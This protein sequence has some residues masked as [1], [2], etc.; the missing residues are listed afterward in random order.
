MLGHVGAGPGSNAS[1][2]SISLCLTG[3]HILDVRAASVRRAAVGIEGDRIVAIGPDDQIASRSRQIV[4]VAGQTIV[5][6]YIEPHGH[7]IIANPVEFPCR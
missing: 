7:V 4:D 1:P 6:G 2:G 5:P 3:G